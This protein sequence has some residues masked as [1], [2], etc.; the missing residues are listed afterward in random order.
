[1]L[2]VALLVLT[3][4]AFAKPKKATNDVAARLA[5][6]NL[7]ALR[8][9][10]ADLTKA[11]GDDYPN[12]ER[13]LATIDSIGDVA[14]LVARVEQGDA[15]ALKQAEELIALNRRALLAN[16]LLNFDRMLLVKRG[17]APKNLG[18]PKNWQSNSSVAKKGY[19]NEIAVLSSPRGEAELSTLYRPEDGA[20]VGEV[21]LD[22]DASRLIFSMPTERWRV[23][24]MNADGSGL[25]QLGTIDEPDVDNYDACY[26]PDGNVLFTSTAPFTGVPCVKGKDHVSNLY[27]F[28]R[29]SGDVRRLTFDQDHDWCPTVLP[30][31]RVLYLRWEYSD[32]PHYVSRILFHMNP[33]GTSQMEFY[34]SN[35]YWPNSMFHARPIPGSS[36][37]FVAVIS[38]H[39]D[40][41]RMG[42]LVLFDTMLGRREAQGAIQRIPGR[43]V[44]VEPVIEDHLVRDSWPKYL[45]PWPLSEKYF[46]VACQPTKQSL[47]GL[48]L[49]DVF[50]NRTLIKEVADYAL[51]EPIPLRA[52]ER[53]P[54]V[55][56]RVDPS[57]KDALIYLA[58]IYAG[59]GL[60]G[61]PRGEVKSLRLF[62]YHFAYH[63]M[64]GQINRVG[65][66]GPWDVK[67]IVGTV[68]VEPD[69]SALFRVPANTPISIQPL[70]AD[71]KAM[72]LMRSWMTAM[73]GETLSCIG[74]HESQ[75]ATPVQRSTIAGVRAPSEIT[76]WYGPTRG[77][78]F[79]REVQPVLD[80]YCVGCHNGKGPTSK[81][82]FTRRAATHPTAEKENYNTGTK[83][84][85]SYIAL[86][87]YIRAPSIES[88]MHM[89]PPGEFHADTAQLIQLLEAGHNNVQLD[90]ESRA[91]LIT[92]I[93][94][95]APAHGTW[96][97]IVGSELVDNQRDR[98]RAL[99]A[100]YAGIN[101][102]PEEV[103]PPASIKAPRRKRAKEGAKTIQP[104]TFTKSAPALSPAPLAKSRTIALSDGIALELALVP[105]PQPFWVG[106][107]E[108]TNEQFA[109]FDSDH[110]SRLEH[111]DFLQFSVQERGYPLNDPKQPVCRVSWE[112]AAAFCKWL[113]DET[114]E[115][116]ALPTVAQ[117]EL[118]CGA[119]ASTPLWFGECDADFA[120]F[121]NLADASLRSVDT[122]GFKLPSGAIPP[123][124]Q[125]A[126]VINDGHRVSAPVG[127]YQANALGLHD[128]HGN[129]AEWTS[130]STASNKRIVCGG[131]WYDRPE[132]ATVS[133]RREHK[134]YLPVFDVGFRVVCPASN[135]KKLAA[136][137]QENN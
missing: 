100:K 77:F 54:A 92:W 6:V 25:R 11:F 63:G 78:S 117:W 70:D 79:V 134:A 50:D 15:E 81:P 127:S 17:L 21:D 113:S 2:V 40:T 93:D 59:D 75:N 114:G 57:R 116:F 119:G 36:T 34:G 132:R 94:L 43:G 67:R 58:D 4:G 96:S 64:G 69:G 61:V 45:N 101:E 68:P 88:D 3:S 110:D 105:G 103:C 37:K 102:D 5:D 13:T 126:D 131:S 9:A 41:A 136:V 33:D 118:A 18:Q 49:V 10:V 51:L 112:S 22:F 31:G 106:R 73:P 38:G 83:F 66:D 55:P 135:A 53:P 65:L 39:H 82:D 56:S 46:L 8:L 80:A 62:T 128:A 107:F 90:A 76:P 111:G 12:G 85:P 1:M 16:P 84:T 130:D 137:E 29:G 28:T 52:T 71:G 97:E 74:C 35:S 91:R 42:E 125:A 95:G 60:K 26:L 32:I 124:R 87:S 108:V 133:F 72:Q 89:L 44:E 47:W 20:Y 7:P 98:R 27:H 123:Y 129:V 120:K 24:E 23:F 14:T 104:P 121:A 99:M 48:Y 86:R 122:F 19:D 109:R 30:N 115:T